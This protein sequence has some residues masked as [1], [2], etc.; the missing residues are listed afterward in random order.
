MKIA[1]I[2]FIGSIILLSIGTVSSVLDG[3]SEIGNL[4]LL[5]A[6]ILIPSLI[7]AYISYRTLELKYPIIMCLVG[8]LFFVLLGD[9]LESKVV[10]I[11]PLACIIACWD[12]S[13]EIDIHGKHKKRVTGRKGD[14]IYYG[15]RSH[16]KNKKKRSWETGGTTDNYRSSSTGST[17]RIS[18]DSSSSSTGSTSVHNEESKGYLWRESQYPESLMSFEE[19]QRLDYYHRMYPDKKTADLFYFYD[20]SNREKKE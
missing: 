2:Y 6:F 14:S 19:R 7:V 8:A 12:L 11:W 1:I 17:G 16:S 18:E 3:Y 9:N 15:E 4:V 10:A 20:R 13:R 5:W